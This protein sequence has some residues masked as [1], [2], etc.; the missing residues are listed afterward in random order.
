MTP[1]QTRGPSADQHIAAV[2]ALPRSQDGP[3]HRAAHPLADDR[4][5]HWV[6]GRVEPDA[7]RRRCVS[8]SGTLTHASDRQNPLDRGRGRAPAD[9]AR[10]GLHQPADCRFCRQAENDH[11]AQARGT[12]SAA[13]AGEAGRAENQ[14]RSAATWPSPGSKRCHHVTARRRVLDGR[15]GPAHH[16][17]ASQRAFISRDWRGNRPA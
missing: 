17:A 16:I 13:L 5:R 14:S 3:R 12:Q 10:S 11:R 8:R 4:G 7:R 15:D 1:E 6:S 9:S 2:W